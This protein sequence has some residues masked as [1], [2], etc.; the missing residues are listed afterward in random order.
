MSPAL[1][2]LKAPPG[3]LSTKI[4]RTFS[5]AK[6][7]SIEPA[8]EPASASVINKSNCVGSR[9]NQ[10]SPDRWLPSKVRKNKNSK[11]THKTYTRSVSTK[12]MAEQATPCYCFSI[13]PVV[14]PQ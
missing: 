6:L 1:K 8:D 4:A 14:P 11:N 5:M 13:K 3:S 2:G 9:V 10:W 7:T 12:E